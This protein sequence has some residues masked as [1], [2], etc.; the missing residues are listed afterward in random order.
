M[1]PSIAYV[2]QQAWIFNGSLRENICFGAPYDPARYA[3]ALYDSALV[4]DLPTLPQG[5]QTPIGDKGMR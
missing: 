1:T 5:D 4:G 2:A 3:R